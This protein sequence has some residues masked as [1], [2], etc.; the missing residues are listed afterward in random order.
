M[1][2]RRADRHSTQ[3][4][5]STIAV[6]GDCSE[7]TCPRSSRRHAGRRTAA[8]QA[9]RRT[10]TQSRAWL[11][12][13]VAASPVAMEANVAAGGGQ[14][15]RRTAVVHAHACGA[16]SRS[17]VSSIGS[18]P[19]LNEPL[20][21]DRSRLALAVGGS[22]KSMVPLVSRTST[23]SVRNGSHLNLH[24]TVGRTHIEA[25]AQGGPRHVAV[26]A[27]DDDRA[28]DIETFT[29]P[30]FECRRRRVPTGTATSKLTSI[31]RPA[32]CLRGPSF[33][34]TTLSGA[35]SS[36]MRTFETISAPCCRWPP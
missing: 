29:S 5:S 31:R 2:A 11:R 27:R 9:A 35:T 3:S 14:G 18:V 22:V 36:T 10:L 16:S 26:G 4:T 34:S 30:L 13:R 21:V 1:R 24:A 32:R 28:V 23:G 7:R 8:L 17:P 15:D 33:R 25:A 19:R 6:S 12:R 20:V